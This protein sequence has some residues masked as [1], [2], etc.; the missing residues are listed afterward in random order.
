MWLAALVVVVVAAAQPGTDEIE[1][2]TDEVTISRL[3]DPRGVEGVDA[4]AAA[5]GIPGEITTPCDTGDPWCAEPPPVADLG[6]PTTSPLDTQ[7]TEAYSSPVTLDFRLEDH[8]L[9]QAIGVNVFTEATTTT[10]VAPASTTPPSDEATVA[11]E[12]AVQEA[13]A[14]ERATGDQR[15]PLARTGAGQITIVLALLGLGLLGVGLVLR[16]LTQRNT[17]AP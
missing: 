4:D 11:G 2:A 5:N 6:E 14:P 16:R 9:S 17:P 13:A 8:Q 7:E 3:R 15:G 12:G 10:T 1:T